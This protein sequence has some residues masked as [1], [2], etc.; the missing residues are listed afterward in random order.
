M[1][2]EVDCPSFFIHVSASSMHASKKILYP[3]KHSVRFLTSIVYLEEFCECLRAWNQLWRNLFQ[4]GRA[5]VHVK[6]TM[7]KFY[8]LNWQ[9]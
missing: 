8:G 2:Q 9:L 1:A 4:S 3:M 5:Q 6:N 7:G